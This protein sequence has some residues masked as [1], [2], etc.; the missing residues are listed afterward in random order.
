MDKSGKVENAAKSSESA[1]E[2]KNANLRKR[3]HEETSTDESKKWKTTF[4]FGPTDESKKAPFR[5]EPIDESKKTTF[6]F[7]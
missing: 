6:G 4:G 2:L 3:Q 7:R 5:F 1:K